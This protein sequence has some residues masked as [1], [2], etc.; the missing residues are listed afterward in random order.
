MRSSK[1][2]III[3]DKA[4]TN[5]DHQALANFLQKESFRPTKNH[6]IVN[7]NEEAIEKVQEY[8]SSLSYI[9][10]SNLDNRVKA[11]NLDNI[12]PTI[13]NINSGNFPLYRTI[14][15][16]YN[17]HLYLNEQAQDE[18]KEITEYLWSE[19]FKYSLNELK[20]VSLTEAE[21]Q[22]IKENNKAIKI[23]VSAPLSGPYT[24]LGRSIVNGTRLA[25]KEQNRKANLN[26]KP[27]E[28]IICDDKASTS[29]A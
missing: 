9:S 25:V 14:H 27:V 13:Q 21:I 26:G 29:T 16:Y 3:I 4:E 12:A 22:P 23:G 2:A 15:L 19:E 17:S 20:L 7:S 28:L 11:I 1:Q 6:F 5:A 18:I 10:F 8:A 24:E